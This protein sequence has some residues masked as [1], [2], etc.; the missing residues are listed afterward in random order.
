[1]RCNFLLTSALLYMMYFF[2]RSSFGSPILWYYTLLRDSHMGL[3][4]LS[5]M[6][7][8]F[9]IILYHF[10]EKIVFFADTKWKMK[11]NELRKN[12]SMSTIVFTFASLLIFVV[13]ILM[14]EV[15]ISK[16]L[17]NPRVRTIV[18][19][20][21]TKYFWLKNLVCRAR[22]TESSDSSPSRWIRSWSSASLFFLASSAATLSLLLNRSP[23][24]YKCWICKSFCT[25][26]E[27]FFVL[28]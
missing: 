4:Y 8:Q 20:I 24:K 2:H 5:R 6:C 14:I 23:R 9:F 26:H 11:H 17:S 16:I 13:S 25:N 7:N 27:E 18:S 10:H 12:K 1:M 28:H 21:L 3:L 15:R 19:I 22:T